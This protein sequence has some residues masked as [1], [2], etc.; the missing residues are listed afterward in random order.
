MAVL[1][2]GRNRAAAA[3]GGL[4]VISDAAIASR[5]AGVTALPHQDAAVMPAY[6]IAQFLLAADW[7]L[8]R[9]ALPLNGIPQ[10][11]AAPPPPAA[12]PAM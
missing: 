4:L 5:L 6:V 9:P 12:P 11:N 7:L 10:P 1:A 3:G 2:S 8:P